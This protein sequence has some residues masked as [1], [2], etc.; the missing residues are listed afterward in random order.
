MHYHKFI[1]AI[2]GGSG[3][4]KIRQAYC[5]EL[6]A[7][8]SMLFTECQNSIPF[9]RCDQFNFRGFDF[10]MIFHYFCL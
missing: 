4:K 7:V 9:P 3:V 10:Y 8:I 2:D 1:K 5:K 6:I